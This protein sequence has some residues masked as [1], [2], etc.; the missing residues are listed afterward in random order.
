[1]LDVCHMRRRRIHAD[2]SMCARAPLLVMEFMSNG[3]LRALLNNDTFPLDAELSLPLLRD[4]LQV[5][6]CV[7]VTCVCVCVCV[8]ACARVCA[9]VRVCVC[10][11]VCVYVCVR[12]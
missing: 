10:V 1:M 8:R 6:V 2:L 11:C 12:V 4:I 7:C 3:S 9:C 5:C